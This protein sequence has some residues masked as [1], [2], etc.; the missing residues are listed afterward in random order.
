MFDISCDAE[1]G[2]FD[3]Q[4]A[5]PS[6][7]RRERKRVSYAVDNDGSSSESNQSRPTSPSG[8][9]VNRG[10]RLESR[11][12]GSEVNQGSEIND[13]KNGSRLAGSGSEDEGSGVPGGVPARDLSRSSGG[14][15]VNLR[16]ESDDEF[17]SSYGC[18]W[19]LRSFY[20]L[21]FCFRFGYFRYSFFLTSYFLV[22]L[23][24]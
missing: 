6:R 9:E 21:I 19:F 3:L 4:I 14:S 12:E 23:R 18:N 15:E 5:A 1:C 24:Q 8:S 10:S 17:V 13:V 16:G 2:L 7:S 20:L 11:N 22:F